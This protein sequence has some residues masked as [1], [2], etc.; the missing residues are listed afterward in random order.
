[1]YRN[2]HKIVGVIACDGYYGDPDTANTPFVLQS[3]KPWYPDPFTT[4][5]TIKHLEGYTIAY[6]GPKDVANF[7]WY[8]YQIPSTKDPQDYHIPIFSVITTRNYSANIIG[9]LAI[10]YVS[11]WD[12]GNPTAEAQNLL[13]TL[14]SQNKI[15]ILDS[16]VLSTNES[17]IE[18]A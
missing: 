14:V 5:D 15:Q 1:M 18:L 7:T 8:I 10:I 3:K 13:Q 12:N 17:F 11:F 9:K 4:P 2:Q 16:S 6:T